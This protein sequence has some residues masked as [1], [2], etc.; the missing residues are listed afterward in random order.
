MVWRI[1]LFGCIWS[2]C[3]GTKPSVTF[4]N[5]Q[6]TEKKKR[7]FRKTLKKSLLR[8][9]LTPEKQGDP[10]F[11]ALRMQK[12]MG[13]RWK[14][15]H[16]AALKWNQKVRCPR[17][18]SHVRLVRLIVLGDVRYPRFKRLVRRLHTR[19]ERCL[20]LLVRLKT[21][22]FSGQFSVQWSLQK[23][24]RAMHVTPLELTPLSDASPY[25]CIVRVVQKSFFPSY[26]YEG[27][28]SVRSDWVWSIH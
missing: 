1:L 3:L 12:A 22:I 10:L 9:V 28:V 17:L 15:W 23:D 21:P 16:K 18:K 6:A 27:I 24:G 20:S 14:A 11:N 4:S 13:S 25:S 8:S 26:V 7:L 19:F 2:V 5:H